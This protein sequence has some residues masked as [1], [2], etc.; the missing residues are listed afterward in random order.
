MCVQERQRKEARS[1]TGS[2]ENK[3]QIENLCVRVHMD[4][5]LAEECVKVRNLD[6][7]KDLEYKRKTKKRWVVLYRKKKGKE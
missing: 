7:S 3:R 5:S 6:E 1:M 4:V 2:K